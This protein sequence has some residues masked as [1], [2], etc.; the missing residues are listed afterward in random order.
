MGK[1]G[2]ERGVR[3]SSI[4]DKGAGGS[5]GDRVQRG[6]LD[7][8]SCRFHLESLRFLID[9]ESLKLENIALSFI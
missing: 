5:V 3:W 2:G 9:F 8:G 6:L 7:L 1:G 4:G